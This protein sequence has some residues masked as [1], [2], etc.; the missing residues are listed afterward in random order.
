METNPDAGLPDGVAEA[1]FNRICI[2]GPSGSGKS[3]LARQLGT[4]LGLPVTELDAIYHQADWQPLGDAAFLQRAAII[5][6]TDR[7]VVDGNY[8]LVRR[9]FWERAELIVVI[10]L[11][12][13][14]VM[15]QLLGRTLHRGVRRQELWNGNREDF[16]SLLSI[17]PRRNLLLWSWRSHHRYRDEVPQAARVLGAAEVVVLKSRRELQRFSASLSPAAS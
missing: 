10:D 15:L 1:S 5:A 3:T 14:Q 11:P 16:R 12:R 17:D 9:T 6:S 2:H 7:W 8:S 13:W 4:Q